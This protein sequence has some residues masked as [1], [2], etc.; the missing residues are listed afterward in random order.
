M[1]VCGDTRLLAMAGS[2]FSSGATLTQIGPIEIVRPSGR[3]GRSVYVTPEHAI[4]RTHRVHLGHRKLGAPADAEL[5]RGG[6]PE[7]IARGMTG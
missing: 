5:L 1:R 3:S 6:P 4:T 2:W 7:L